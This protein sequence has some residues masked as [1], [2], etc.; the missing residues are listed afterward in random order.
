MIVVLDASVVLAS[1]LP[2]EHSDMSTTL[3]RRLT[4][5]PA[6]VPTLW[7]YEVVAGIRAAERRGRLDP[8]D[9]ARAVALVETLPIEQHQPRGTTMLHLSRRADISPSDASYLAVALDHAVPLATFDE[10][11]R[12]AA[13]T[14]GVPLAA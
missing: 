2:D 3:M 5:S 11:M 4:S 14:L 9:A 8:D 6:L 13:I 10:R 1:L 12:T 7:T